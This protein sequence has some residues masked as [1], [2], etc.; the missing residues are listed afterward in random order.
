MPRSVGVRAAGVRPGG[1]ARR[2]GAAVA[3][4]ASIVL[5]GC[6][7]GPASVAIGEATSEPLPWQ[8]APPTLSGPATEPRSMPSAVVTLQPGATDTPEPT[9]T[10]SAT[11]TAPPDET[12][13]SEPPDE[14]ADSPDLRQLEAEVVELVDAERTAEGCSGLRV[15]K[16]LEEAARGHSEDMAERDYFDHTNPDGEGPNKRAQ[17]EGYRWWSAEN[18]A[19][20]YPTAEAVV[21][22]WMDSAGHRKNILDCDSVATGVGVA[23]SPRGL[24]W[25][26]MFGTR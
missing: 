1:T 6:G 2:G 16:R 11:D 15:D 7:A 10:P 5:A 25:T 22:G 21:A 9:G 26:Q 24:Y 14:P 23:D 8:T 18:I 3:V 20:G 19:M 17:D 12:T 13:S 4:V